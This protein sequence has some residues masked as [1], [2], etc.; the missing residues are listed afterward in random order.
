MIIDRK[1]NAARNIVWGIWNKAICVFFPFVIRTIIIWKLGTEYLGISSLFSSV[2]QVLNLAE[3]GFGSALVFSMY[4]PIAEDDGQTICALLNVYRKVYHRI[5][6]LILGAGIVLLPFLEYVIKGECPDKIN[7][8]VVYLI[9]LSNTTISY[10]VFAYRSSLL[11]A[12]NRNDVISKIS[13]SVIIIQYLVQTLILCFAPNYYFY[14][15]VL[16]V[17]TVALNI[18]QALCTVKM[19]PDYVCKGDISTEMRIDIRKRV[20]GLASYKI[21][22]VV[23]SSVDSIVI[24]MFLGLIPLGIYNN[25]YYIVA[26]V[27]AFLVITINSLTAGIGNSLVLEN[28]EKNYQDFKQ[29]VFMNAWLVGWCAICMAVLFQPFIEAWI[30]KDYWLSYVTVCLLVIMFYASRV[31]T[32]TYLYKEALGLWWEDRIRPLV[33]TIANLTINIFLVQKIGLNGVIISTVICTLFINIPCGTHILFKNYFKEGEVHYYINIIKYAVIT[34]LVGIVTYWFST[35]V[36]TGGFREVMIKSVVCLIIPN[37]C[38]AA[39][40]HRK[41]EFRKVC[42]LAKSIIK[43][44]IL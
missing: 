10:F 14:I 1:K 32:V 5:G 39:I 7:V 22:G 34:L 29:L 37:L 31:S 33:S 24:S 2:L 11:L 20:C 15:L 6:T 35:F 12:H 25:Y 36:V 30:G 42:L 43:K 17:F 18:I 4:K 21:Y 28:V 26:S 3:L 41:K 9:Y 44:Y 19:Y 16:P 38:F 23:F 40:Y 13:T 8:Y 27:E